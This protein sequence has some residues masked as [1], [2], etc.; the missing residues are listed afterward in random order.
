MSTFNLTQ[1]KI[2]EIEKDLQTQA[3]TMSIQQLLQ[4]HF[5]SVV[6]LRKYFKTWEKD[7][8]LCLR[9]KICPTPKYIGC[10]VCNRLAFATEL[11]GE[12]VRDIN[13]F[14]ND[15]DDAF[16][17]FINHS[18]HNVKLKVIQF[19]RKDEI[20]LRKI[21]RKQV[22]DDLFN[23]F[24]GFKDFRYE[25]QMDSIDYILFR[26]NFKSLGH[27]CK[28]KDDFDKTIMKLRTQELD[29]RL[30]CT[31]CGK[32]TKFHRAR[33]GD[34]YEKCATGTCGFFHK[35]NKPFAKV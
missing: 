12:P 21:S 3:L 18:Y 24:R 29:E 10:A 4:L 28:W 23:R 6:D 11:R 22:L 13:W 8:V 33:N 34:L 26:H 32:K 2:D 7:Q 5:E 1:E 14:T 20:C 35:R 25:N 27:W 19:L 31:G 30:Y 17:I 15:S 9:K 16:D